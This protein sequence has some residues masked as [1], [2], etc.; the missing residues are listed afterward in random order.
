MAAIHRYP[1]Y[2]PRAGRVA[3]AAA[4]GLGLAGCPL[5]ASS[6]MTTTLGSTSASAS[7]SESSPA[8]GGGTPRATVP[9]LIGKTP[10]EASA[11]VKAAGFAHAPEAT[12]PLV[13]EGAFMCIT[14]VVA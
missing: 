13:C 7:G 6:S 2:V 14:Y 12:R 10:E 9:Y 5:G 1:R 3:L 11:I 8:S 4:L